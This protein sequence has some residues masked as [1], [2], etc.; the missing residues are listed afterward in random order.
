MGI[1]SIGIMAVL[2]VVAAIAILWV[3]TLRRVVPTNEVH[4]VQRSN[5]TVSYGKDTT[6]GNT[7]WQWPIWLPKIGLQVIKLPVNNFPIRL[8]GYEAYDKDRLPFML[9]LEAFFRIS[10]P[11][12]AAQRVSTVSEL[13]SQLR[14]ILEGASRS[15]LASKDINVIMSGRAEFGDQFTSEVKEQLAQWGVEPV[16]NIELM[17]IRDSRGSSVIANVMAKKVS[18]IERDSRITVAENRKKAE[19]SE[20]Q[21]QREVQVANEQALQQIGVAKANK[22]REIGLAEEA[23]EQH[24]KEQQRI[25]AEKTMEVRRVE[26]VKQA[27][28]TKDVEVV[29]AQEQR[30]TEV[31]RAEGEK[32]KTVLLSEGQL[33]SEKMAA[34]AIKARG[35]AEAEALKLKEL[36]P[37][38]AQI[39]LAQEIGENVGY[40]SYLISVR[41]IESEQAIGIEQ[42][43]ALTQAEVKVIANAGTPNDGLKG[44]GE[45]FSSSGGLKL[46]T[47][48]EG[49]ANTE[50]GKDIISKF[51]SDNK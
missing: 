23:T 8:E 5:A 18:E 30:A 45:L 27:E 49:L 28:I 15:M 41:K 35:E 6:N 38:Q 36:A 9:D 46:G 12:T 40:Q 14:S 34:E 37:V 11:N 22:D 16:K 10:D 47:M 48:L 51:V 33:Q 2:F 42:A 7:Y 4:I 13:Q 19:E 50:A 3:V 26:H 17:D 1:A 44:V 29:K 20:I 21:N 24:I 25:T 31:E 39:T 43:K 32:A